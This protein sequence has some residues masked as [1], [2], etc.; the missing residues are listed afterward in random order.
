VHPAKAGRRFMAL[1]TFNCD[2]SYDSDPHQDSERVLDAANNPYIPKTYVVGGFFADEIAWSKI[3]RSWDGKNRRVGV[4]HFH[5]SPLNAREGEYKG[6]GK[7][8]QIRYAKDML[9]ILKKQGLR[10]HAVSCGMLVRDYEQVISEQGRR[11]LGNPYIACFKTC[12]AMIARDMNDPRGGFYPEDQFAVVLDRNKFQTEAVDI[13]YKMKDAAVFR[14]RNRLATCTPASWEQVTELQTADL[15]AYETFKL[16]HGARG[17]VLKA[18]RSL[19]SM[20]DKNGFQGLYYGR[21]TLEKIKPKLEAAAEAG[22][23]PNG[24]I[25][26]LT[27]KWD[28]S[29]TGELVT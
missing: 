28:P 7:N 1:F 12:V 27:P 21:D 26:N 16:L 19:E 17:T 3:K 15:I 6:W 25:I 22:C 5:A 29:K 4:S 18:R 24:F 9:R 13:F 10:L 20:F 2:E 14:D 8:R 23:A 11:S